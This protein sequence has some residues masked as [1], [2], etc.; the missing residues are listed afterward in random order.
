[1]FNLK[2][3]SLFV[4]RDKNEAAHSLSLNNFDN[5][6]NAV[7]AEENSENRASVTS[8]NGGQE[9]LLKE[10]EIQFAKHHH[11]HHHHEAKKVPLISQFRRKSCHCTDCGGQSKFEMKVQDIFSAHNKQ[12]RV[13]RRIRKRLEQQNV[14]NGTKPFLGLPNFHT[15]VLGDNDNQEGKEFFNENLFV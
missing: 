11:H 9:N 5:F 3:A 13:N 8:S 15:M 14:K 7:V 10:D 2:I 1:M 12:L 4:N 6:E